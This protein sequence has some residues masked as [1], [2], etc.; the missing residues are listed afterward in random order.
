MDKA[1]AFGVGH[2]VGGAEVAD[3]VPFAFA[4]FRGIEWVCQF[5]FGQIILGDIAKAAVH[6]AIQPGAF[7]H[8]LGQV[9]SE[10]IFVADPGP[11]FFG[12]SVTS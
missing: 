7:H 2:K 12:A 9:V 5:D 1:G 11:A 4:A 3:V 10:D 8:V 6:C